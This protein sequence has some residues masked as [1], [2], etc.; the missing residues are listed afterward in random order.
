MAVKVNTLLSRKDRKISSI[1]FV[2]RKNG[3]RYYYYPGISVEVKNWIDGNKFCKEGKKYPDGAIINDQLRQY[4]RIIEDVFAHFDVKLIV[5][6]QDLFKAEVDRQIDSLNEDAGG[7]SYNKNSFVEYIKVRIENADKTKNTYKNLCSLVK[8]LQDYESIINKKLLFNDIDLSFYSN[9][10]NYMIEKVYPTK[11]GNRTY[12]KNYISALFRMIS[13]CMN[14]TLGDKHNNKSYSDKR[15]KKDFEEVDSV[16]LTL[17]EVQRLYDLEIT[18]DLVRSFYPNLKPGAIVRKTKSLNKAR[19]LFLSGCYTGLRISD[20]T[21]SKDFDISNNLIRIRMTKVNKTV[22]IP[23]HHNLQSLIDTTDI[24]SITM[25]KTVLNQKVKELGLIVGITEEV[26]ITR[27]E[28]GRPI[29]KSLPKNELIC[30]HTAR[31][32]FAT[33][34]YISGVDIYVIKDLL[35][36]SKIE[37]TIRY[38]RITKE[39]NAKRI[40]NH[41]FF[42][43]KEDTSNVS[44]D[45]MSH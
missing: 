31:R 32:S 44:T 22:I 3:M 39:D 41:P 7:V 4:I 11:K 34:L 12:S 42:G 35:G 21:R 5:P 14:E 38:L 23:I 17:E 15:F 8:H 25:D 13:T 28:G 30:S 1:H 9:F 29:T 27:T 19:L 36:H 45:T 24:L 16:Y 37:T 26:K 20:Y 33:N 6:T 2:V 43:I 18:S 40:A 10:R